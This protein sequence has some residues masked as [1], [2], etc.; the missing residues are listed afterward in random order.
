LAARDTYV[1]AEEHVSALVDLHFFAHKVEDSCSSL[2]FLAKAME[3]VQAILP[4]NSDA[5][6]ERKLPIEFTSRLKTSLC[7]TEVCPFTH[8]RFLSVQA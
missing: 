4:G 2:F 6:K 5:S 1:G 7:A 3:L 8:F